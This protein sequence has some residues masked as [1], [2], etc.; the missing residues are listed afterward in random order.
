MPAARGGL[1]A[2]PASR[3]NGSF[4]SSLPARFRVS[5]RSMTAISTA[6]EFDFQTD[7]RDWGAV[8]LLL[9]EC[10]EEISERNA[11][12]LH[13]VSVWKMA[14]KMLKKAVMEKMILREPGPRDRDYHR[15]SLAF[16]KGAGRRLLHEMKLHP[17]IDPKHIGIT[18]AD[19]SAMVDELEYQER[20]WYGDMKP[21]L[22]DEILTSLHGARAKSPRAASIF[23]AC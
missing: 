11:A 5:F 22:R 17:E 2:F 19:A 7:E 20:E 12:L 13:R 21:E 9:D 14:V 8:K 16:L 3:E 10:D 15:S 23:A 18:W 1:S 4:F 6:R